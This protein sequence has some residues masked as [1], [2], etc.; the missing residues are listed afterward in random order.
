MITST[1]NKDELLRKRLV[2]MAHSDR[3]YWSFKGN[4]R[5]EHGHGL[6]QYPAMMV[7][8]MAQ[9]ILE[10]ICEVHPEVE[11]VEDPFVGSGTILTETMLRGRHFS[12]TDVN[13]LAVLLCKVKFRVVLDC[14]LGSAQTDG[15]R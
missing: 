2:E 5:R 14:G 12:G 6:F 4:S 13:P 7:P 11:R 10:Q 1:P 15:Q 8:Q 3:D 9:T